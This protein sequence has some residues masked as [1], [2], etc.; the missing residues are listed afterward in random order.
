LDRKDERRMG[1]MMKTNRIA[2]IVISIALI[3]IIGGTSFAADQKKVTIK[4][5]NWAQGGQEYWDK[6]AE[7]FSRENPSI[8]V[9]YESVPF[10][11]YYEQEGT[12]LASRSGPDV[13]ANNLGF[14]LWERAG[15]Y[16]DISKRLTPKIKR[17]LYDYT[18]CALAFDEKLGILGIAP[19]YQGN[20]M[21]YNRELFTNAG[22]DPNAPPADWDTFGKYAVKV[23]ASGKAML[24]MGTGHT[25]AYWF[26]PEIAKNFWKSSEDIQQFMRG[27]IPWSDPRMRKVLDFMA[28]MADQ[29]WYQE[30]AATTTMLPDAG[31][32]FIR[33]DTA[34][35][36][37]IASDVFN[38]KT[39]GDA[40]GHQNIGVMKWPMIDPKAP[41]AGKFSG[42]GGFSVGIAAWTKNE[43]AAWKYV[44]WMAS[45]ENANLFL[46]LAGGQPNNKNFDKSIITNSPS[47][48]KIQSIISN[49]MPHT[50]V[51]LSGRELDAISR[52]YE[53]IILKQITVDDW[54]KTM[55]DALNDS[56]LKKPTAAIW[57]H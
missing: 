8:Q 16:K 40:M 12:Y 56:D 20:L 33:G 23:K 53:Q 26:F 11:R 57:N 28:W 29:G 15:A 32:V 9:E 2:I 22:L 44:E 43:E 38:W 47:F 49:N 3:A 1:T 17:S 39:W 13:M 36:Y 34:M 52:G 30:G 24:A 10:E 50:G 19:S 31:D 35:I 41:F 45:E 27:Q 54:A 7:A 55:Q 18:G 46:K 25:I 21:Y 51:M 4:V 14:E 42:V 48:T 37:G 6:T 5:L